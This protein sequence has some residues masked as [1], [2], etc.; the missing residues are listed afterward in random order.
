LGFFIHVQEE[1]MPTRSIAQ[2]F[3]RVSNKRAKPLN[4]WIVWY[5]RN[6]LTIWN[7]MSILGG[8]QL[9]GCSLAVLQ[10]LPDL[11]NTLLPDSILLV[12]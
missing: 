2:E 11:L 4:Q 9:Q 10:Q 6:M 5:Q 7:L 12:S 8:K 1:A 3:F